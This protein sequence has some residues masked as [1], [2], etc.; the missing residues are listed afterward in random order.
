M[1]SRASEIGAHL[2]DNVIP[3]VPVRQWVLSIPMPLRYLAAYNSKALKMVLDAFVAAVSSYLKKQAKIFGGINS[4]QEAFPGAITFIQRFGSALNLNVHFHTIFCDGVFTKN[5]EGR[6]EFVR[7]PPPSLNDIRR[8]TEKVA[9]RAHRW[10]EK[11]VDELEYDNSLSTEEPLLARCY[12]ASGRYL[13]ATGKNA[14]KPLMRVIA[15][16]VIKETDRE[17][18]T[19]AG[20]NIHASIPVEDGDRRRLERLIRYMGRPPISQE[21]LTKAQDGR[22]IVKLKSAWSDGTSYIILTPTE[23]IERLVSIIPPPR[24]NQVRYHG[25]FAPR[26]KMRKLVVPAK[27]S[28]DPDQ[29]DAE[30][31]SEGSSRSKLGYAKLMARVF[32]IDVLKCP[33]CSSDM[34]IISF[35]TETK[36]VRDILTSLKMSTAPPGIAPARPVEEQFHFDYVD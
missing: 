2:V 3:R 8:I 9:K 10:L 18:R 30:E 32:E 13:S 34:Q 31:E 23:L 11:R 7:L 5:N 4:A 16:K 14:G 35:I 36:A 25:V 22:I 12:E 29:P 28:K 15:E 19:V 17:Q 20:F 26:S 6:S 21:R 27:E 24:K 1:A 33:R